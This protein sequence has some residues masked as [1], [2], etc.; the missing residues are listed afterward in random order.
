MPLLS[1]EVNINNINFSEINNNNNKP[2]CF[3]KY[4][5][6]SL[7]LQSPNLKFIEPIV[8]NKTLYLFLSPQD[9]TTYKFI[10]VINNIE[11]KSYEYINSLDSKNVEISSVIKSYNLDENNNQIVKYLKIT[12]LDNIKIQYNDKFIEF[13][14]L[15]KLVDKVNLKLIFEINMLWISQK[16]LGIYLKPIKIKVCDIIKEIQL[17]FR[18]DDLVSPYDIVQTEVDHINR[19]FNNNS[20]MSLNESVFNTEQ[21]FN[22]SNLNNFIKI[23]KKNDL[24]EIN[25]Q[26]ELKNQLKNIQNIKKISDNSQEIN[27]DNSDSNTESSINSSSSIRLETCTRKSKGKKLDDSSNKK[28]YTKNIKK[29]K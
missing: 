7:F 11:T 18:D 16:K 23:N 28:K 14:E 29:N 19:L 2:F 13:N 27:I 6:Q 9:P 25:Y 20:I 12:L 5:T 8:N 26:D 24:N 15:D 3:I 22:D 1:E 4:N 21:K 10:N 17:E